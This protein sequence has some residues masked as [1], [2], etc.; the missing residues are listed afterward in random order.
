MIP[1]TTTLVKRDDIVSA[2]LTAKVFENINIIPPYS[3]NDEFKVEKSKTIVFSVISK[4]HTIS[5]DDTDNA[6]STIKDEIKE[7]TTV[8]ETLV[9]D[10]TIS[11]LNELSSYLNLSE[12]HLSLTRSK[13]KFFKKHIEYHE[14]LSDV[15]TAIEQSDRESE[16][17]VSE[18]PEHL[19][20]KKPS[21]TKLHT[22]KTA[23]IEAI[24]EDT[25]K[26]E[27][28][29]E[30]ITKYTIPNP[31]ELLIES[32]NAFDVVDY[33]LENNHI[34]N[35]IGVKTLNNGIISWSSFI[36]D[37]LS[38]N[39]NENLYKKSFLNP[40]IENLDQQDDDDE[41][42]DAIITG[43]LASEDE[44]DSEENDPNGMSD[45]ELEEAMRK[46]KAIE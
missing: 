11:S 4:Y 23:L 5:N 20:V 15:N 21:N 17:A 19:V 16:E 34:D 42:S 39:T 7:N 32:N 9:F 24:K 35:V 28:R 10:Q 6:E 27:S 40:Q 45:E 1:G 38:G 36:N 33:L 31:T 22:Q 29:L 37:I 13:I 43:K 41:G 44:E 2:A 12:E 25:K 8:L 26:Q 3:S 18:L 30:A 46:Q 14:A